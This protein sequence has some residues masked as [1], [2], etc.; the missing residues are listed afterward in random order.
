MNPK[1]IDEQIRETLSAEDARLLDEFGEEPSLLELTIQSMT[2]R[3][4]F[5]NLMGAIVMVV[6][7]VLGFY[8]A[9]Q[10][11]QATEL[12]PLIG[13]SLG[14]MFCAT[15]VGMMKIWYWMELNKYCSRCR[16]HTLHRETK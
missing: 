4:R 16:T 13:W 10:F 1:S 5:V 7:V 15:T 6:F 8:S 14:V 11:S 3:F 9:W 2:S 12:K